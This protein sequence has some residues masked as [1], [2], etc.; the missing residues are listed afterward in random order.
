ML[1]ERRRPADNIV[2]T[3]REVRVNDK[4]IHEITRPEKE[5]IHQS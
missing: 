2:L 3:K 4:R 1:A 5:D